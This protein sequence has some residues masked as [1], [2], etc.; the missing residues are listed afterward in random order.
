M[1]TSVSYRFRFGTVFPHPPS[2]QSRAGRSAWLATSSWLIE[3][4]NRLNRTHRG[5]GQLRRSSRDGQDLD[6]RAGT[7]LRHCTVGPPLHERSSTA[8]VTVE[9]NGRSSTSEDDHGYQKSPRRTREVRQHLRSEWLWSKVAR[10]PISW[11][12]GSRGM[13]APKLPVPPPKDDRRLTAGMQTSQTPDQKSAKSQYFSSQT[14][15]D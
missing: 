14:L 10:C 11:A 7:L 12:E 13:S 3:D 8:G 9:A 5:F 6:R 1:N 4:P 15:F 2:V